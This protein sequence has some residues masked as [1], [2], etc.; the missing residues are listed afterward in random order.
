[1]I[2]E[3]GSHSI[4]TTISTHLRNNLSVPRIWVCA[5]SSLHSVAEECTPSVSN[6]VIEGLT[7]ESNVIYCIVA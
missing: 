1:M 4:T 2:T 6:T 5:K 7:G 3:H